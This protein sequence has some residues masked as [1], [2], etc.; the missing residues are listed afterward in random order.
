MMI[1]FHCSPNLITLTNRSSQQ[2]RRPLTKKKQNMHVRESC[3][4][5]M[6]P[7]VASI[8]MR[9]CLSSVWRRRL[10][11]STLPSAVNLS[12]QDYTVQF[13]RHSTSNSEI[14]LCK[15]Y[16]VQKTQRGPRIRQDL[17][18]QV[19]SQTHEE[20]KRCSWPSHPKRCL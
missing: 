11:F 5:V 14:R 15:Q 3:S 13:H 9:P 17:A 4:G 10:K 12:N 19:H 6:Y 18:H 8:E 7:I 2:Q 20:A 16:D 1:T